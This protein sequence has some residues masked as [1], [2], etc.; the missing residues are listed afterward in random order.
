METTSRRT[1][2]IMPQSRRRGRDG[3]ARRLPQPPPRRHEEAHV[4]VRGVPRGVPTSLTRPSWTGDPRLRW[5]ARGRRAGSVSGAARR[6]A[7]VTPI[8][9]S[10]RSPPPSAIGS[11][12]P[13]AFPTTPSTTN[14]ST[15]SPS[16]I[17]SRTTPRPTCER[18]WTRWS[19]R[20]ANSWR[21]LARRTSPPCSTRT[22]PRSSGTPV[23]PR[24]MDFVEPGRAASPTR[25]RM[26]SRLI[27]SRLMRGVSRVLRAV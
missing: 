3:G 14:P 4:P 19:R 8:D 23:R 9:R 26:S 1:R 20:F 11:R 21:R 6:A 18:S 17:K 13:R 7:A 2:R 24:S 10:P 12:P 22:S 5:N 27:L 15:R 16:L 25:R